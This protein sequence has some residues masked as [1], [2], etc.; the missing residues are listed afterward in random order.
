M[1]E[2]LQKREGYLAHKLEE[3]IKAAKPPRAEIPSFS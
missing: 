3:S 2:R 1:C